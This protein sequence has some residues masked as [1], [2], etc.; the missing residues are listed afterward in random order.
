MSDAVKA[1]EIRR[2]MIGVREHLARDV[3]EIV[4][5]AGRLTDWRNYVASFPWGSLGAAVALGFMVVPRKLEIVSPD[6]DTLEKLAKSNRLVVEHKPRSERK[7]GFIETAF[8]LTANTLLR[9][10]IAYAGRQIGKH[11]GQQAAEE[12]AKGASQS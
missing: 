11:V 7:P 12:S 3:D 1:E 5:G 2:E 6:A 10:G 4:D 8:T 9:A